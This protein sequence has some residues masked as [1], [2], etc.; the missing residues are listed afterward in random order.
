MLYHL[1]FHV[2]YPADMSQSELF[3]IW[4]EEADTALQAKAEGTVVDLWKCLGTRRIIA[5]VDVDSPDVLDRILMDLPIVQ[6]NGQHVTVEVTPLRRY[7]DFAQDVK[8]RVR[9]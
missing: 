1:D 9:H 4:S 2:S 8:A 6:Q 7:E 5:I 3:A